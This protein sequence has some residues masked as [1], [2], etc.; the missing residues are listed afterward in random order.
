VQIGYAGYART[1]SPK[2]LFWM[3]VN[4]ARRRVSVLC[5]QDKPRAARTCGT[6]VTKELKIGLPG[7]GNILSSQ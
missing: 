5:G 4:L 7:R 1:P 6:V 3:A 2:L